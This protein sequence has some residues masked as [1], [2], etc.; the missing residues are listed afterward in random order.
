MYRPEDGR[1]Y[2]IDFEF[3]QQIHAHS[4]AASVRN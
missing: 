2:V 3:A 1:F 4:S